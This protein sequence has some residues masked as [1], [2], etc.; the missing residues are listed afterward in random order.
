MAVTAENQ[1]SVDIDTVRV[2]ETIPTP[3]GRRMKDLVS[4]YQSSTREELAEPA[5]LMVC[6]DS[7]MSPL[8]LA[9]GS[10]HEDA[11]AS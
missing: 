10:S 6:N 7:R 2:M 1:A 5:T 4:L 3:Q 8:W 11:K 9:G